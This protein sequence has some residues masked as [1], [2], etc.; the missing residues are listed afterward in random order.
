AIASDMGFECIV[1]GV[2]TL[3]QLK[4][5]KR[6]NCFMAQGYYFDRPLPV[7]EFEEKLTYE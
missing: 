3:E 5:I 1:E 4:L 2:E 7:W 6:N